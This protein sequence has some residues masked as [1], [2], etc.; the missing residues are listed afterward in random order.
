M[1]KK[2]PEMSSFEGL[3]LGPV[4]EGVYALVRIFFSVVAFF[5][6]CELWPYRAAFYS[7]AGMIDQR[8]AVGAVH[9]FYPSLFGIFY[10]EPAVTGYFIF[11]AVAIIFLA[12]GCLPR[13]AAFFVFAWFMSCSFR[14]PVAN[15]GW[16]LTLRCF[17]FLILVSPLGKSWKVGLPW[18]PPFRSVPNYGITLMRLQVLV[19]YWQTD[20]GRMHDPWW[21]NGDFFGY[22]LL[23]QF[24]RWPGLWVLDH[25]F[26]M[27]LITWATTGVEL[28]LPLLLWFRRTRWVGITLGC[29]FHLAIIV[30]A[31]NIGL[32]SLTMMM[33]YLS[34]LRDEDVRWVRTR[35]AKNE[36]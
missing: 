34:F 31:R 22:F 10:S 30:V 2:K 9:Y 29:C 28:L 24:S 4:D 7:S 3:W 27:H 21:K 33:T 35:M 20:I 11:S 8:A 23:S 26:L 17:A 16:D 19:I 5:C 13:L 1:S 25:L 32:F 36:A 18:P 15:S 12:I 6:L 14:A